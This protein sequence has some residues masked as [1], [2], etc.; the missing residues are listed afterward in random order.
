MQNDTKNNKGKT[1]SKIGEGHINTKFQRTKKKANKEMK[2][3]FISSDIME[4]SN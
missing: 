2:K 1:N 4:I 3:C